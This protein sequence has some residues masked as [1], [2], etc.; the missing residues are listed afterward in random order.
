[1]YGLLINVRKQNKKVQYEPRYT[2]R[3]PLDCSSNIISRGVRPK[4]LKIP[5]SQIVK[6]NKNDR[7]SKS[8]GNTYW[9]KMCD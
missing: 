7:L 9:W 4:S 5:S 8:F 6:K 2:G 1:M 3:C